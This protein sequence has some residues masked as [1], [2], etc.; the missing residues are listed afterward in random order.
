M[1]TVITYGDIIQLDPQVCPF[2][3]LLGV[4]IN[5]NNIGLTIA[6]YRPAADNSKAEVLRFTVPHGAYK[7]VGH[8]AWIGVSAQDKA[9]AQPL[10]ANPKPTDN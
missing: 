1:T 8:A 5:A 9:E 2:G 6:V 4:V 3:A 7:I 10:P